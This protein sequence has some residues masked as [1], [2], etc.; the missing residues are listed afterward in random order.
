MNRTTTRSLIS[1][2]FLVQFM[3]YFMAGGAAAIVEWS[4]FWVSTARL[5]I[6][7][8]VAVVISFILA[9]MVNYILSSRFV[10]GRSRRRQTVEVLLVYLVSAVGLGLNSLLMWILHG[11]LQLNAMFAKVISTGIVFLWNFSTRR[12]FIFQS[13]DGTS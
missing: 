2:L 4:V 10:F 12:W 6:H 3:K 11:N 9:T 5:G 8:L 1:S 13:R 7:Y